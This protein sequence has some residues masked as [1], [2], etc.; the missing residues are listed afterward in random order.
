MTILQDE[1]VNTNLICNL[2]GNPPPLVTWKHNGIFLS[3]IPS[4]ESIRKCKNASA[5]IYKTS[6][7]VNELILCQ[8]DYKQHQGSFECIASNKADTA[9]KTMYLTLKGI[10]ELLSLEEKLLKYFAEFVYFKRKF[11]KSSYLSIQVQHLPIVCISVGLQI[12]W[13]DLKIF[14]TH[15]CA[16][17]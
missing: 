2:S 1:V 16:M 13:L 9:S 11:D 15:F 4:L 8:L 14:R 12:C 6:E 7:V 17:F 10:F 5:G 3:S